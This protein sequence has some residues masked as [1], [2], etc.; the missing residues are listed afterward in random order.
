[1]TSAISVLRTESISAARAAP[2][3]RKSPSAIAMAHVIPIGVTFTTS[4]R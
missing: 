4:A 1:M 2:S 3:P